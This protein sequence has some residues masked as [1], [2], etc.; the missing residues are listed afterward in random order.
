MKHLART[1]EV[2]EDSG[3]SFEQAM[4]SVSRSIIWPSLIAAALLGLFCATGL[5]IGIVKFINWVMCVE[6]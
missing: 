1:G 4:D 5:I 3:A 2:I 6:C